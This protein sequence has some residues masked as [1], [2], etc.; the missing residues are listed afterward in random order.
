[1]RY[2]LLS[3]S[4]SVCKSFSVWVRFSFRNCSSSLSSSFFGWPG[5]SRSERS[6]L[7]LRNVWN[8]FLHVLCVAPP[9]PKTEQIISVTSVTFLLPHWGSCFRE[10]KN[11]E[12]LVSEYS[13][14]SKTSRDVIFSWR[15]DVC[16]YA[17]VC[18]CPIFNVW[19]PDNS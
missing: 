8:Y 4:E 11:F 7:P 18:M 19:N 12:I 9:F 17:C 1:M 10:K 3:N 13:E 6:K 2:C 16:V 14:Y 15:P 5:L